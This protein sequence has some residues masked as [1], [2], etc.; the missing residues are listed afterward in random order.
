[1]GFAFAELGW[2]PRQYMDATA[3]ELFAAYEWWRA[4]N[5][6]EKED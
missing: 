2:T 3:Y 1:M 4:V 5:T 6:V